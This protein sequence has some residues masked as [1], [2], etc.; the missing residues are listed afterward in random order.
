ML[1]VRLSFE[2]T[3]VIKSYPQYFNNRVQKLLKTDQNPFDFKGLHFI[4]IVEESK[5]LNYL[6]DPW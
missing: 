2:A 1:T 6:N 4:K 5:S 3:Q